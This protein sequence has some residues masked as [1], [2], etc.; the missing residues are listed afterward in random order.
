SSWYCII[1]AFCGS[2]SRE[3]L[4]AAL[5]VHCCSINSLGWDGERASEPAAGRKEVAL[6]R[7]GITGGASTGVTH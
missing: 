7:R 3:I 2:W 4:Y 5:G 1:L 6:E